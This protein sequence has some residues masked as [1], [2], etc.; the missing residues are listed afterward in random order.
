MSH[1]FAQRAETQAPADL[2]FGTDDPL[3]RATQKAVKWD[4]FSFFFFIENKQTGKND[5]N[6]LIL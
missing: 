2:P 5:S 3:Q 6:V 1:D 4:F